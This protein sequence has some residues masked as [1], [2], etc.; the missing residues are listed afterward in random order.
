MKVV[1]EAS[2]KQLA[3]YERLRANMEWFVNAA[4]AGGATADDKKK[5][6]KNA[7]QRAEEVQHDALSDEPPFAELARWDKVQRRGGKATHAT[8]IEGLTKDYV[9]F[10]RKRLKTQT[11]DGARND[12][13]WLIE[14][15]LKQWKVVPDKGKH[16]GQLVK[17]NRTRRSTAK[18]TM[19]TLLAEGKLPKPR[20]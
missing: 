14:Q 12:E 9:E 16:E 5:L 11:S 15:F 7:M 6:L 10:L 19:L 3:R 1:K 8:Y 4:V 13:P 2:A 18:K 17:P 20:V